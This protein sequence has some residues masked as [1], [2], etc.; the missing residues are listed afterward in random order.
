MIPH[1]KTFLLLPFVSVHLKV[2]GIVRGEP[3]GGMV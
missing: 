3:E 2:W 1:H